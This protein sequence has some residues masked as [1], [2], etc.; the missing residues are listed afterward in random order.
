MMN[1]SRL[2]G[3]AMRTP[4]LMLI[5]DPNSGKTH[6]GGQLYGRL[7][8]RPAALQLRREQGTPTDLTA[9]AEVLRCLDDG[10]SADHTATETWAEI[11]LPLV[12]AYGRAMDLRWPDYGGE[13]LREVFKQRAVREDWRARLVAADGWVLL[14]RLKGETK[15]PDALDE[16]GKRPEG[17]KVDI[18]R[19][20]SWDAN[21]RWVELLQILLHVAGLGTVTRLRRPRLTVLLSCYDELGAGDGPPCERL[22]EELPL[23]SAFINSTWA[24]GAVSIWGLSALGRPLD[25]NISDQDFVDKGPETQGWIVHPEG[26]A[27]DP[28]LTRP[29]AWL[30]ETR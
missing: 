26:G 11:T 21:A 19:V 16:L 12:D 3:G 2:S 17:Q 15:Y 10:R 28:D 24:D 5:G 22:A 29:L 20:A 7:R 13:Q 14:I 30:L 8:R 9:L 4:E 25:Q 1:P 23:V 27:Q 18:E 6:F